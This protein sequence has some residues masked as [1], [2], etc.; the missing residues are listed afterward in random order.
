MSTIKG[1]RFHPFNQSQ[2]LQ[3]SRPLVST[4]AVSDLRS[5]PL[6]DYLGYRFH[7]K[8]LIMICVAC[9]FAVMPSNALGHV[10]NQHNIFVSNEQHSLWVQTVD[11]WSVIKNG[12][13][14]PP[15]DHQPVELLKIHNNAYCCVSCDYAALTVATFSKH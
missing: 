15:Q 9:G 7:T 13:V 6:L 14:L 12:P 8:H 3:I 4:P 11:E 10:R 5:S 2:G 1:H